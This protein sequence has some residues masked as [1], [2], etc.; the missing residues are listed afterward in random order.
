MAMETPR[1]E[2]WPLLVE[3][4]TNDPRSDDQW[5]PDVE[6]H[7]SLILKTGMDLGPLLSF[8]RHNDASEDQEWNSYYSLET[9][10]CLARQGSR[11]ALEFRREYNECGFDFEEITR[12]VGKL[13]EL[14]ALEGIDEILYDRISSDAD[15]YE[16]LQD[17]IE[18]DWAKY[19]QMDEE[20][21]AACRLVL[22]MCEP[23]KSLCDK[24]EGLS[25][26]F[27]RNGLPYDPPPAVY[28]VTDA[29]VR[30]LRIPRD[31]TNACRTRTW[32]FLMSGR[33]VVVRAPTVT[34]IGPIYRLACSRISTCRSRCSRRSGP[35]CRASL[36]TAHRPPRRTCRPPT[37]CRYTARGSTETRRRTIPEG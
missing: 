35:G 15:V 19:C 23:W 32:M 24:N 7:A 36:D 2:V 33:Q 9:L 1:E 18:E 37:G 26:L 6:Y 21:R 20:S 28:R 14:E 17:E 34:S 30:D 27:L 25:Q 5:N 31:G 4:V 22:P 11:Q 3:C 10:R 13:A 16:Q 29:D 8:V 12:I